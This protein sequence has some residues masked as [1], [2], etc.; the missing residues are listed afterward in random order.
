M[1]FFT[2]GNV[3]MDYGLLFSPEVKND[4]LF[5]YKHT[6]FH[7]TRHLIDGLESCRLLLLSAACTL[8][9]TAPI[10]CNGSFGEQV[11]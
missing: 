10:H 6:D 8:I 2:R 1:D 9:L 11:I 5:A 3:I 7:F 4:G